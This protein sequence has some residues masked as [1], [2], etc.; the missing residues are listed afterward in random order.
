MSYDMFPVLLKET[1][2]VG[3]N[4]A[5]PRPTSILV[6]SVYKAPKIQLSATLFVQ[7]ALL[8][9]SRLL[10]LFSANYTCLTFKAL[11]TPSANEGNIGSHSVTPVQFGFGQVCHELLLVADRFLPVSV[12]C[13]P[14][15]AGLPQSGG[16]P[17]RAHWERIADPVTGCRVPGRVSSR[18]GGLDGLS[19]PGLQALVNN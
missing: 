15:F 2:P 3:V 17:D 10:G 13:K 1:V 6:S 9:A 18:P 4:A 16:Q 12:R 11:A 8:A 7:T 19:V 14:T 5:D